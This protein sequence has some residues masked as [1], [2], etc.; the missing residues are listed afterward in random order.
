[1]SG[2]G[3]VGGGGGEFELSRLEGGDSEGRAVRAV[4]HPKRRPGG[5][6]KEDQ[7]EEHDKEPEKAAAEYAPA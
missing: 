6:A 5:G 4:E 3:R 1:M 2:G 7:Q